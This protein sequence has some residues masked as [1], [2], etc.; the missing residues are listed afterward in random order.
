[1]NKLRPGIIAKYNQEQ[2]GKKL[3]ALAETVMLL[4]QK[5][6]YLSHP[7]QFVIYY[8]AALLINIIYLGKYSIV[9]AGLRKNGN[10]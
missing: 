1:M 5:L 6:F 3:H 7:Y 8:H 9:S 2:N 4:A 10:C